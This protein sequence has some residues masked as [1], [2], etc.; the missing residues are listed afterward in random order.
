MHLPRETNAGNIFGSQLRLLH[1][2]RNRDRA[3][4]PP[5]ARILFRPSDLRRNKRSMFLRRRRNNT[6]LPIYHERPRSAGSDIN[7]Q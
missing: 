6:S 7:A 1:R 4:A 5:V 3:G 2:P